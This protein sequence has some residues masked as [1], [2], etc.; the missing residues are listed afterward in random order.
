MASFTQS[1]IFTGKLLALLLFHTLYFSVKAQEAVTHFEYI[2]L[3]QG[4]PQGQILGLM[5][6][7]HGYIW[8][9]TMSGLVRYDGYNFVQ[10]TNI[11]ADSSSLSHSTAWPLIESRD[12]YIW[13]GSHTGL[14]RW[15]RVSN[16]FQRF[17]HG[18]ND[19]N[20]LPNNQV[21]TA[22]EDKTGRLWVGT[23]NGLAWY[24]GRLFHRVPIAKTSDLPDGTQVFSI[25]QDEKGSILAGTNFGLVKIDPPYGQGKA[26]PINCKDICNPLP[27][28]MKLFKGGD[29]R[30]WVGAANGLFL[31]DSK[32]EIFTLVPLKGTPTQQAVRDIIEDKQGYLWITALNDNGLF[33]LNP[34]TRVLEHFQHTPSNSFG[35]SSNHLRS[36]M[37]DQ[38]NNLWI[39]TY[40]GLNKINLDPPRFTLLQQEPGDKR[41]ENRIY[42]AYIGDCGG[43]WF[44][45]Y[46]HQLFYSEQPGNKALEIDDLSLP[47][48]PVQLEN[49]CSASEGE[50]WIATWPKGIIRYYTKTGKS[51]MLAELT[52]LNP[53]ME[54][55]GYFY[56]EEDNEDP[57][58]MWLSS[59]NGLCKVHKKTLA[60]AYFPPK[61][62]LPFLADNSI[63]NGLQT[64][65]NFIYVL[66]ESHFNGKLGRFDKRAQTYQLIPIAGPV[67]GG[68]NN[69]HIRQF[70]YTPDGALWMA[71]ATGLGKIA[72]KSNDFQLLTTDDGMA[73]NNLM[74]IATDRK[75]NVWLKSMQHLSKYDPKSGTFW[76][77]NVAKDMREFN[78]VGAAVA[79]D[80]RIFF[81]GNNGFYAFYPD[82]V[83]L[84]STLPR[85]VLTDFK[86]LNQSRW[87]GTSP[88]LIKEITLNHCDNVFSFEFAAL[89]F[90]NP[91]DNR[92][93]H[94]LYGFNKNWVEAGTE[95]KVTYTNLD[96]GRYTFEVMACNADGVWN[97]EP[98][99]IRLRLLPPPWLT[100]WAYSLYALAAAS[101]LWAFYSW[102]KRRW[103]LK[104]QLAMGQQEAERLK[105]LDQFKTNFYTN[106]THEFRTPLTII[107]GMV[108]QVKNDPEKWYNEGLQ[109]IRRSGQNL[110]RLVNQML[111]LSKLEAGVL[112]VNM[113]QGDVIAYLK[114]VL[115]SFHS[116][117]E[118]KNIN[119]GFQSDQEELVMD[120]DP[121]K[122]REILSNL[123]SN[124]IKFT[125]EGG[126]VKVKAGRW[127]SESLANWLQIAVTDN[128]I[129]IPQERL[130]HIFGR[131]YSPPQSPR[132]GEV[133]AGSL[134]EKASLN[135]TP[136]FSP[137]LGGGWGEAWGLRG[138]AGAGIGLA[139]TKELVNL[140]G[141][142]IEVESEVNKGTVFRVMLPV[143]KEAGTMD[144]ID[145]EE[146]PAIAPKGSA[147]APAGRAPFIRRSKGEKDTLLIIEDNPDVVR[148]I[149]SLLENEYRL[150]VAENGKEGLEKALETVPDIILSDVMM[151]EMDGFELCDKLKKDFRTSH[152]PVILLT[153]KADMPSRIEGLERGADA[154]LAKPFHKEELVVRLHKLLELRKQLQERYRS[155]PPLPP[156]NGPVIQI[157]DDFMQRVRNILETHLGDE[158]FG[159]LGLCKELGMS[160]SQFYRKFQA[161]S[162]QTVGLYFRSLRLHKAKELLLTSGLHISEIAYEVGFKDPAHFTRAFKEE[163]GVTPSEM[164]K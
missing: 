67:A 78:S 92:Y 25:L 143:R 159:I 77:F 76:H 150:E 59:K 155:M 97:P 85:V 90:N 126:R 23:F 102:R 38:L 101:L 18:P 75:G 157:E 138:A 118:S 33:R 6:D 5:Q 16:R 11:P 4:L 13:I 14:N 124:A 22:F 19:P 42:K 106:I 112:P 95:R 29:G 57:D 81:N 30:I 87:F 119:L 140:L 35:L 127:K 104:A 107:L 46:N 12:G 3:E 86:V 9:G 121:E 96:A 55:A 135:N 70:A 158:Y 73:E 151:P 120:Y 71:T 164:R 133:P 98:L 36:V 20:S 145:A 24:D 94:R 130:Q 2:G 56:M 114:Y 83:K 27:A 62:D 148:Y 43:L 162:G 31:W 48:F 132:W 134:P 44:R 154:Y 54:L 69:I 65:D 45:A 117:A 53:E 149:S 32:K 108:E 39:G 93:R 51:D 15:N 147:A 156:A 146:S 88:E 84:D 122:L 74:G 1:V 91:Q 47:P 109:M 34:E 144:A 10:Y 105:E 72:P 137:S 60:R 125:P 61:Q 163:F 79:P 153:A 116:L 28:V 26:F 100:W 17:F 160:R 136:P 128:G 63:W 99:I 50:I 139:L 52:N 41:E 131:F 129:G 115:E 7:S 82:S 113:V 89:H 161:L 68:E 103:Q 141:G 8:F 111:D 110:L 80:N 142:E 40:N 21:E 123:L 58:Y 49:F 152:I 64:P 37:I 66:F